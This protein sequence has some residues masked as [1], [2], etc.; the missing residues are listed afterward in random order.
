LREPAPVG[1]FFVVQTILLS[2]PTGCVVNP[3]A[4]F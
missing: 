3:L 2:A 1:F 4:I